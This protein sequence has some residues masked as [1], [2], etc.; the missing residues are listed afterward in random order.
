MKTGII[1]TLVAGLL[2]STALSS[3]ALAGGSVKDAPAPA[4]RQ[5]SWSFNIGGTSDYV[6]RG[7]SQNAEDPALQG[8][9]D[10]T[11]GI[12]YAG[13]WS[14][15]VGFGP[16]TTTG[17]DVVSA[18]VDLYAGIKPVWGPLTFDLG[19][20][21]YA[22]PG[23]NDGGATGWFE[24]NFVELKAG[25]SGSPVKNLTLGATVFFSPEYINE[26]GQTW[27]IEGTAGY[28]FPKIGPFV[29]TLSSTLGT[30]LFENTFNATRFNAALG[31]DSYLY[32]NAGVAFAVDKLTL[33]VR[34]WDNDISGTTTSCAQPGGG[35][36]GGSS[37]DQRFVFSAKVTLP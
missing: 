17:N 13:I 8:G 12:F 32:W 3:V 14:S 16:T 6:F 2:A 26:T 15:M 9:V 20:I 37:C 29:P 4:G 25:V 23:A 30:T 35:T 21:Y 5:L 24:Q 28:E 34:Y 33:D 36:S 10:L 19:V 27:T 22:Y 11:Y 7:V 18:E 31:D 1:K